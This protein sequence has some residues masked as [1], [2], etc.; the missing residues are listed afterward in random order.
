MMWWLIKFA[1][2]MFV[3]YN[4]TRI[5]NICLFMCTQYPNRTIK[6]YNICRSR[7]LVP[8]PSSFITFFNINFWVSA[9]LRYIHFLCVKRIG[10][11]S[12]FFLK[13]LL[14]MTRSK[15]IKLIYYLQNSLYSRFLCFIKSLHN[16]FE[17]STDK[18]LIYMHR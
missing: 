2:K 1:D 15:E 10:T 8:L 12:N 16:P 11:D 18:D 5:H 9:T 3:H 13:N 14:K 6:S 17:Y 4:N 7:L